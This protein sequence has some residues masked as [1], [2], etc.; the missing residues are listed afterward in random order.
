[1]SEVAVAH[2]RVGLPES[3]RLNGWVII[4]HPR[5]LV[6]PARS[7]DGLSGSQ[8]RP[9]CGCRPAPRLRSGGR[10][11]GTNLR[12]LLRCMSGALAGLAAQANPAR[13]ASISP[14]LAAGSAVAAI[15][16]AVLH[17]PFGPIGADDID[18]SLGA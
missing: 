11:I 12:F 9:G 18:G 2:P 6:L 16:V 4:G 7:Q 3:P 8:E 13:P 15:D 10:C 14:W 1:M 17:R 5:R